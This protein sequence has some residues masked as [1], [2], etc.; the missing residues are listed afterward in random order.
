MNREG[1]RR[2]AAEEL[3]L[4]TS[5]YRFADS[6]PNCRPRSQGHRLSLHRQA[7]DVVFR[8][9]A[10]AAARSPGD[11]SPAWDYAASGG[12]V[13]QGR[14]IVEGVIDFDYEITLLTVRAVRR[15]RRP[16]HVSASRSAT[17]RSPATTSN[18]GSRRR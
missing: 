9:G 14:V 1:I 6:L 5:P 16:D 10:V 15:R 11:L 7:G 18:P 13:N 17:C 2:L 4:P 12:R 8:Q 3:G